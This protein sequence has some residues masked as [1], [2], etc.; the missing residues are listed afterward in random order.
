MAGAGVAA[1]AHPR[2]AEALRLFP[3]AKVLRVEEPGEQ[4]DLDDV[5]ASPNVIHVDFGLRE[6]MD[7][8]IPD[9]EERE[10]D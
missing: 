4:D 5:P 3:G 2:V 9:P 7:E 10:D 1:A 8:E 6:R